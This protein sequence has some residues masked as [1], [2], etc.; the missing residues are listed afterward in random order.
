[1]IKPE[2][3][4]FLLAFPVIFFMSGINAQSYKLNEIL[5][6]PLVKE[7]TEK[8]GI[9]HTLE[10]GETELT[11]MPE[12]PFAKMTADFQGG[13]SEEEPSFI[14]ESIYLVKKTNLRS[15][16]STENNPVT[17]D[18]VSR[19]LRSISKMKGME[20]YSNTQQ[21]WDIL[22]SESYMIE[23][24]ESKEPIP[25]MTE[26]SAD[27]LKLYCFQHEH[28]FGDSTYELTY[29]QSGSEVSVKFQNLDDLKYKFVRAVKKGNMNIN[30]VVLDCGDSFAVY[31]VIQ[32]RIIRW[33][34]LEKRM[35][36][37]LNARLDAIY[38]WFTQQF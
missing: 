23:N 19:V 5:S 38:K 18:E 25:D 37:S 17:L 10:K 12:T 31:M 6:G 7:L 29:H 26:G 14:S 30:L 8:G 1:M 3:T 34:F 11:L 36:K 4:L 22:Y 15:A 33:S 2:K 16:E 9:K 21:K 35:N 27:G 28:A 20:Y 24:P 13:T 32:A